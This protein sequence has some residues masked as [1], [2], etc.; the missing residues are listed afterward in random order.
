MNFPI[1]LQENMINELKQLSSIV[2]GKRIEYPCALDRSDKLLELYEAIVADKFQTDKDG[3]EFF[4][5]DRRYAS[6]YFYQLEKRLFNHL[7]ESILFIRPDER[8]GEYRKALTDCYKKYAVFEILKKQW[9]RE[10]ANT[11]GKQLLRKAIK[12]HLTKI[13]VTVSTSLKY[14]AAM[15]SDRT[16]YKKYDKIANIYREIRDAEEAAED[17]FTEMAIQVSASKS[18]NKKLIE[19]IEGF[20]RELKCLTS[21]YNSYWLNLVSSNVVIYNHKI[22]N[23]YQEIVQESQ[24]ALSFFRSLPFNAP[25]G[26]IFSFTYHLF[27]AHLKLGD[28]VKANQACDEAMSVTK[29]GS[30]NWVI[31]QY[32]LLISAFHSQDFDLAVSTL[33]KVK[34]FVEKHKAFREK[35]LILEAYL[36]FFGRI[37]RCSLPPSDKRFRLA[38]FLNEVPHFS[39]DKR[40]MNINI[41]LIQVLFRLQ[42]RE[43]G[44]LIDSMESLQAYRYRHLRRDDTF[45]SNCFIHM[46]IQLEKGNFKRVAVERHAKKY[47]EK[48]QLVSFE[49]STQDLEVEP[50][51]YEFLWECVLEIL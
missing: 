3:A 6:K 24:R 7:S 42:R 35:I 2:R 40:G 30:L 25:A 32:Y 28:F 15:K 26:S 49:K 11:I 43:F 22:N 13:V 18:V 39:K 17:M 47:W 45:R 37:G 34:P 31:L 33:V 20:S 48:L 23:R 41:L 51:R 21:K 36:Q 27:T 8:S 4:Y 1:L 19:E 5:Q 14:T 16:N 9:N 46:I 10:A 38:K 12:Y 44:K 29:E 50:V